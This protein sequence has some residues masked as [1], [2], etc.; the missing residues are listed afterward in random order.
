MRKMSSALSP[1]F[2]PIALGF[3]HRQVWEPGGQ[4]EVAGTPTI[5]G[6]SHGITFAMPSKPADATR[7]N[8]SRG[9]LGEMKNR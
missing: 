6:R 4:V 5:V 3:L 8:R 2:G 9:D 7:T 1:V